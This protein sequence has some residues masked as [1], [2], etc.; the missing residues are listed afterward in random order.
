MAR[1]HPRRPHGLPP[2][3]PLPSPRRGR[4]DTLAAPAEGSTSTAPAVAP[5][6]SVLVTGARPHLTASMTGTSAAPAAVAWSPTLPAAWKVAP[7]VR[8]LDLPVVA[9]SHCVHLGM[10][11]AVVVL[12]APQHTMRPVGQASVVP[13]RVAPLSGATLHMV[14]LAPPGGAVDTLVLAVR[15][16]VVYIPRGTAPVE[17]P[18]IM[19]EAAAGRARAIREAGMSGGAVST[20][21]TAAPCGIPI[22]MGSAA[23]GPAALTLEDTAPHGVLRAVAVAAAVAGEPPLLPR[24]VPAS[25]AEVLPASAAALC[26][27]APVESDNHHPPICLPHRNQW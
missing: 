4:D 17:A 26:T 12:G 2:P 1:G 3:P 9:A 25:T 15:G 8:L 13:W 16:V 11:V 20:P 10:R 27:Q 22:S 18:R 23:W 7:G 5:S 21:V 19:T 6:V 24:A 14:G